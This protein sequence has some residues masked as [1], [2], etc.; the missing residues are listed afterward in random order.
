MNSVF[1]SALLMYAAIEGIQS[2]F[3]AHHLI[4]E[5]GKSI[6][7]Q[8]ELTYPGLL[9]GF[10]CGGVLMRSILNS[11]HKMSAEES[12]KS[13]FKVDKCSTTVTSATGKQDSL[14]NPHAAD[15]R[16]DRSISQL[17]VDKLEHLEKDASGIV[18]KA[19]KMNPER[20]AKM[21][22]VYISVGNCNGNSAQS[23]MESP[24][25]SQLIVKHTVSPFALIAC[26][27]V[28]YFVKD[29]KSSRSIT[30]RSHSP[31]TNN[32]LSSR[33]DH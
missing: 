28:V 12:V 5:G 29:G 2:C 16:A 4:Y 11:V 14:V 27:I 20:D 15:A 25:N 10:A 21:S 6:L 9:V 31:D 22:S 3:H 7:L 23:M 33:S 32:S 19:F 13:N 8:H 17:S 26:A 24:K 30:H 18:L 1:L